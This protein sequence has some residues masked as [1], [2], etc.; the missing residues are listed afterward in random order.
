MTHHYELME[1][2]F[3][4]EDILKVQALHR[5]WRVRYAAA[6]AMGESK[7]TKWLDDIQRLL[8]M[9]ERRSLYSQPKVKSFVNSYDDTRMA[10]M[11]VPIEVVFDKDHPE[12]LLEDW[13]CRGRVRQACLFAL[14]EIG[15]VNDDLLQLLYKYILDDEEDNTVKAAAA[16]VLGIAGSS[17]SIPILEKALV[18]DEWCLQ[19]EVKKAIRRLKQDDAEA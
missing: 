1:M 4:D 2:L 5:D 15:K 19:T 9:E 13:R 6:S 8:L 18:I 3:G 7:S 10:E 14:Y 17:E 16:R 12:A 11:L